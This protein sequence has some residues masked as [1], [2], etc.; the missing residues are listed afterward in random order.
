MYEFARYYSNPISSARIAELLLKA[1]I[2]VRIYCM[3]VLAEFSWL[4][5]WNS[6]C[7]CVVVRQK[8]YTIKYLF[9]LLLFAS[10]AT[11]AP[12]RVCH[13]KHI[14]VQVSQIGRKYLQS[15]RVIVMRWP[16]IRCVKRRFIRT[17]ATVIAVTPTR[18]YF[19]NRIRV[20][21][22]AQKSCNSA[23]FFDV[24]RTETRR[25]PRQLLVIKLFPVIRTGW[26]ILGWIF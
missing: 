3:Y 15:C 22:S 12:R 6:S 20:Q 26:V 8:F 10:R 17:C 11:T 14:V 2:S 1:L 5:A 16:T 13:A 25:R 7:I 19:R 4:C 24:V 9:Q 18:R 21:L 23:H